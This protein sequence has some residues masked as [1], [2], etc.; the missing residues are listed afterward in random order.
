MGAVMK[1][2]IS[3]L[4]SGLALACAQSAI[5]QSSQPLPPTASSLEEQA[6][7]DAVT[8]RAASRKRLLN[9]VKA[10]SALSS[11][12]Q[13]AR[14]PNRLCPY[15]VGASTEVNTYVT[16]RLRQVG[17]TVGVEFE[18]KACQPNLMVL[19]SGEPEIMLKRAHRAHKINF[20]PASP[21]QINR[22]LDNPRPIRWWHSI[23]VVPAVATSPIA[24]AIDGPELIRMENTRML[25]TTRSVIR[26][27]LVVVDAAQANG[28]EIG[29]L[30]DYIALAALTDM[31][32]EAE[33]PGQDTIL[34]L[35]APGANRDSTAR[36]LTAM[37]MAYLRG[38]YKAR[39]SSYGLNQVGK[40]ATLMA[41]E[42]ER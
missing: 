7:I 25:P 38:V 3:G 42:L 36:R 39:D 41:Q 31:K 11:D 4:V 17:E 28:V 2:L 29:A 22:F 26:G 13:V 1:R 18:T 14:R 34:N 21:T 12:G 15:V 9:Y 6:A 23:V 40:I 27:S 37:D 33:M 20:S 8:V 24:G 35:F 19:F 10:V 32:P 16:S 5:A 30:A